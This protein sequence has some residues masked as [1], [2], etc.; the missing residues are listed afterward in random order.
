MWCLT[1]SWC[2]LH[3]YTQASRFYHMSAGQVRHTE[4][5]GTS[6]CSGAKSSCPCPEPIPRA[7]SSSDRSPGFCHP[8]Q[9]RSWPITFGFYFTE[10]ESRTEP[11]WAGFS[12]LAACGII[13]NTWKYR[14]TGPIPAVLIHLVWHGARDSFFF[15]HKDLPVLLM[16]RQGREP[17]GQRLGYSFKEVISKAEKTLF[18]LDWTRKGAG[19]WGLS[20]WKLFHLSGPLSLHLW[21]GENSAAQPPH[22][23]TCEGHA[24][25][26]AHCTTS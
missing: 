18:S 23:V 6:P 14:S 22:R 15:P 7:V 2:S 4:E 9:V 13:W 10:P 1:Q 25:W 24:R 11:T 20:S 12:T 19:Y 17:Q 8:E 5:G 21:D 3:P 26:C 16:C